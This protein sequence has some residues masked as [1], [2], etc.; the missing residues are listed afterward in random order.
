MPARGSGLRDSR[1][2]K[3]DRAREANGM[4]D[5]AVMIPEF[6]WP[7]AMEV[8]LLLAFIF[9]VV[10][11]LWLIAAVTGDDGKHGRA[12]HESVAGQEGRV[13]SDD[14]DQAARTGS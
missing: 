7:G 9:G 13:R 12:D 3:H 6:K 5:G 1:G 10:L 4:E 8:P 11:V 2:W 14:R